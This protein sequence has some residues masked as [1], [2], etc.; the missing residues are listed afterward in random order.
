MKEK[1]DISKSVAAEIV[2]AS[3]GWQT[4][5]LLDAFVKGI[6]ALAH[7]LRVDLLHDPFKGRPAVLRQRRNIARRRR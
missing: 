1:E 7:V 4:H 3:P 5:V 6:D 2:R